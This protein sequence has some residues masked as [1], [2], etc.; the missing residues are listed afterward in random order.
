MLFYLAG[1]HGFGQSDVCGT[2]IDLSLSGDR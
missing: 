2:N 1:L